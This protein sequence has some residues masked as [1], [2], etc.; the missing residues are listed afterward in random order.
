MV[1]RSESLPLHWTFWPVVPGLVVCAAL[2]VLAFGVTALVGSPLLSPMVVAMLGG[3]ILR[4]T[5]ALPATLEPGF[6]LC[7]KPV[8]RAG[9]VLLGFRLTLG[10]IAD[11][12]LV[13]LAL[14]AAVLFATFG[15]TLGL[16]RLLGVERKLTQLIAA[17]TSV[18]GA[19]A[20]MGVNT[21]TKGSD[22]DVAYA[23]AC[24]T[25]F[26]SLAMVL[27]PM[28][29][30]ILGLDDMTYG[31][32]VGASLHEVAQAVGAGFV[33]GD[34]AG[35]AATVAKLSRVILLAPLIFMLGSAMG[36]QAGEGRAPVPWFVLGFLAMVCVNSA[37][38]LPQA[39]LEGL[40]E[41]SVFMLTMALGA[42]GLGA[43]FGKLRAKGL[44]PLVLGL[45]A[46]LVIA[47]LGLGAMVV[48]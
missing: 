15:I 36:G 30:P 43:R 45:L 7:L 29:G 21:V 33:G 46:W 13:R 11:V 42:M 18:C 19:S 6:A 2:A 23:I 41:A 16:G 26:G 17:G 24:V 48:A 25:L 20:V 22:E 34:V 40:R 8:L 9:I 14:I 37:L 3:M 44:R 27:F 4:N 28:L 39:V 32:W 10:E 35:Q 12:G 1:T 38:S 31:Y 5:V 47:G